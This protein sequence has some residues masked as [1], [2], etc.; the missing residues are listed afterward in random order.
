MNRKSI[1]SVLKRK[2]NDWIKSIDDEVVKK[3]I[4]EN[5][6]I[7]GGAITSLLLNEDPK[8][9][10]VYFTNKQT[11][12]RVAKYYVE[13]FNNKQGKLKNRIGY[14]NKAFVLDGAIPIEGQ[15]TDAGQDYNWQSRMI[16]NLSDDRV[17][18]IVRSDGCTTESG[19]IDTSEDFEDVYDVV[20]H[21]D[22]ISAED[23]MPAIDDGEKYRPVFLSPNAI[24]LSNQIQLVIRFYGNAEEIHSNYDYAHC[25]NYW[26]SST[27]KTILRPE[28]VESTLTRHLQYTGSLYP[29]CSIIRMRKFIK[30]G[31]HINAGQ[32]LKM[33]FQASQLDLTNI[34]V[35]EEQLVGV[36]TAYFMNLIES[37]QKKQDNDP[38]FVITNDYICSIIDVIF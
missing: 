23:G 13:K 24:T 22:Q 19:A 7:T 17:K 3:D 32:I 6:I 1:N 33:V 4:Q 9:F 11:V 12:K 25:T 29:V 2:F 28:A 26:E 27:G 21:S 31:W 20:E 37:L 18:I 8:D 38:N 14:M 34:D 10:D 35:L 36:D 15:L 30:R 5:T 16:N